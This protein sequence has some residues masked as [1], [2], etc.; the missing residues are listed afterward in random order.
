MSEVLIQVCKIETIWGNRFQVLILVVERL[1][2]QTINA[3]NQN[4]TDTAA[5][6]DEHVDSF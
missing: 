1:F 6:F 3:Y 4:D 2:L 5:R